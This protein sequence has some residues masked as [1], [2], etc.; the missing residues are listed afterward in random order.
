MAKPLV[1]SETC[2]PTWSVMTTRG[3]WRGAGGRGR[4]A[5]ADHHTNTSEA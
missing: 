2:L 5:A 4:A 3:Q 1:N